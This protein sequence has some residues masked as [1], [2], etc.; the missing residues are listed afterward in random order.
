M[1]KIIKLVSIFFISLNLIN[2]AIAENIFLKKEK[3]NM[4]KKNMK[5]L[6][7]YFKEVLFLI[8]KIKTHIYI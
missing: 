4:M 1:I 3:L 6:N 5:S 2:S 8:P 7:S